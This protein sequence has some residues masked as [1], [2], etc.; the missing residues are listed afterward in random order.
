MKIIFDIDGV[1]ADFVGGFT[2]LAKDMFDV[3]VTTTTSQP[4]WLGF[5]GMTKEQITQTWDIVDAS[6][7]FWY[8]LD[9]L[10]TD[11]ELNA[12]SSISQTDEVYFCTARRGYNVK[13]QTELWLRSTGIV[14][15][16]VIISKRKGEFAK[17]VEADY[18]IEDKANNASFIDWQTEG[19]TKSY[20][21][22]RPYNQAP[23]E[24]LA[25]GVKR[26]SSIS[27][28]LGEVYN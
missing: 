20:L 8:D 16:T 12:I 10:A 18:S 5:P 27:E 2:K 21:I 22:D 26:V 28:F 13:A 11:A 9:A 19:K 6:R 14:K 24:F 3:P 15:P 23:Q 25:S 7:T 4:S 17:A 1:L